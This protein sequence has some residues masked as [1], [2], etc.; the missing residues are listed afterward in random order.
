[1]TVTH[2]HKLAL[3]SFVCTEGMKMDPYYR[4]P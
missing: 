4:Q 3:Y 1:M 2:W